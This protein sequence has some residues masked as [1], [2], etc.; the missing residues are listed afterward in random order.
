MNVPFGRGRK[1]DQSKQRVVQFIGI[2]RIRPGFFGN[3][4]DDGWIENARPAGYVGTQ[5]LPQL[6]GAR[7]AFFERRVIQKGVRIRVQNL[8]RKLRSPRRIDGDGADAAIFN[9]FED[10]PQAVEIH[11]FVETVVDGL[12]HQRMVGNGDR[13]GKILRARNLIGEDGRQ[14]IVRSHTLDRRGNF[15]SAA[16]S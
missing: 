2:P 14:Q 5:R 11:G 15:R 3:P 10:T 8:V 1:R 7:A 16:K 6:H 9:A 13:S 12:L 4:V